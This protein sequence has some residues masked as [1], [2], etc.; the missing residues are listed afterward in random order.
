MTVTKVARR[1]NSSAR[2]R[3]ARRGDRLW[4]LPPVILVT[5]AARLP[6][7]F[8]AAAALPRGSAVIL[9][10]YELEPT[11]RRALARRL[12]R[13]C[14]LRG[15]KLLVAGD[16]RLAHDVGA[17]GLH[18][19]EAQLRG[20]I[21]GGPGGRRRGWLVTAAAHSPAGVLRA[22]RRGADAVLLSPVFPTA[23]HPGRRALGPLRFAALTRTS[24]LPVY[25]LGGIDGGN[26]RRLLVS[27][28]VGLAALG[29]LAAPA[30]SPRQA[31]RRS[32][33]RPRGCE[34]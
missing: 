13:L 24:P 4:A 8:P 26:A 14:R 9:R 5:D 27:A 33:G 18:L 12:K 10:H 32:A 17:D 3:R 1:L 16:S 22:G 28:A 34:A 23:S 29:A 25:A 19:R 6:D 11:A 7:P 2:A 21:P 30:G 15:L 31:C 20:P